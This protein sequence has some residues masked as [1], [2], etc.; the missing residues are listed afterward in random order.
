MSLYRVVVVG[1]RKKADFLANALIKRKMHVSLIND[2]EDFCVEMSHKYPDAIVAC[3]DGTKPFL[4]EDL[5]IENSDIFIA[6]MPSDADNLIACQLAKQIF[7]VKKVF[8]TVSNPKNVEIFKMLGISNVISS[9]YIVANMIEQL[10]TL[11]NIENYIPIEQGKVGLIETVVEEGTQ[12]CFKAISEL[13]IPKQSI[14]ACIF[15]NGESI[16]PKGDTVIYPQDKL[17][18]LFNDGSKEELVSA[19]CKKERHHVNH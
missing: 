19:L 15:R 11:R 13:N 7:K 17:V 6:M 3:G 18:C 1:G 5:H 16:I 10:A 4:Y 12:I 14:I 9:T 2:T 8:C